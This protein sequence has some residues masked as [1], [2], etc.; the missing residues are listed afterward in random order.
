MSRSKPYP[1]LRGRVRGLKGELSKNESS[2][3]V[4]YEVSLSSSSGIKGGT[5]SIDEARWC[6]M[7][8]EG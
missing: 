6:C 7:A 5:A 1:V 2:T 3:E 4:S 8:D